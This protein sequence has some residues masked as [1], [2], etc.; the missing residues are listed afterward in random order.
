MFTSLGH[1]TVRRRRLVLGR[2]RRSSLVA[3]RRPR[4]GRVRPTERRRLR[5]PRRRV[6]PGPGGA[7]TRVPFRQPQPACSSSTADGPASDRRNLRAG[8][9]P[10]RG[11]RGRG[12]GRAT[13]PGRPGRG[14]G[15]QLLVARQ[16][17][18]TAVHR[19]RHR[20]G[21]GPDR[22]RR[23]RGRRPPPS[24]SIDELTG[25][26]GPVTVAAAGQAP[27]I[28]SVS[29][30]IE[31]DLARAESV[32][33]P[34]TLVLLVLVFGGLVAAGLP[35]LVGAVVGARHLLHAVG[36][37]LVTDVSIFSINL[38]TALG[39]G[40][41]IDYSL[42]IVSRFREELGRRPRRDWQPD[43]GGPWRRPWCARWRPRAG[44]SPSRR[45]P[46][47]SRWRRCS[48]SR[49]TSCGPSPTP[50]SA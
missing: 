39:L 45:S 30:T 7:G 34:I 9:R 17:G 49:C 40:L 42:F 11:R 10:I 32:A 48:C 33:V 5:R 31:G 47:P 41:A 36:H 23:G 18:P 43:D 4:L 37:L 28:A 1:L 6:D 12:R 8:D 3:R 35:L 20:H 19:R 14:R 26:R 16:R 50:A 25:D 15:R 44:P 21:R 29:T 24:A 22:R 46:S 27:V 13:A 2:L 38:V